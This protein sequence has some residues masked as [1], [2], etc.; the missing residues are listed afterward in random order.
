[1]DMVFGLH[2]FAH[3][4]NELVS[5]DRLGGYDAKAMASSQRKSGEA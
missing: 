5:G 2:H 3:A 4:H 1:M